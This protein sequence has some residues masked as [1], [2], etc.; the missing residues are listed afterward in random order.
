MFQQENPYEAG[1]IRR[2]EGVNPPRTT[3][4][5]AKPESDSQIGL[6]NNDS[7]SG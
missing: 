5:P 2:A 6:Q 3:T 7:E 1:F 4:S